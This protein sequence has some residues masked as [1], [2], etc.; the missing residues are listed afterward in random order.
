MKSYHKITRITDPDS[1]PNY[2]PSSSA[3][4]KLPSNNSPLK[5][6]SKQQEFNV[7]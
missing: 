2:P 7:I 1:F 4:F 5:S 3:Y 6:K